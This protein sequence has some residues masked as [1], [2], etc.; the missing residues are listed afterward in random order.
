MTQT[1]SPPPIIRPDHRLPGKVYGITEA[2]KAASMGV[3]TSWLQKDRMRE[4]PSVDFARYGGIVRY[5]A[6]P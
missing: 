6:E 3:S 5:S 1:T 2:Q 4:T